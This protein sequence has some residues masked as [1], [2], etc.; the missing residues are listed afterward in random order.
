MRWPASASDSAVCV[1]HERSATMREYLT[2]GLG[3]VSLVFTILGTAFTSMGLALIAFPALQTNGF[4]FLCA[5]GGFLVVGLGLA[6]MRLR[7]IRRRAWLRESGMES[8]GTII[9]VVQNP[10]V[11]L[12]GRRPWIVRYRYEAQGSEYQGRDTMMDLPAEY[13]QGAGVAVK[14]NPMQL[15]ESVLNRGPHLGSR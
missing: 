1:P 2:S 7:T 10:L 6:A 15:N 4:T 12:N 13:E 5:G 9:D 11:R 3:I 8:R 14:F